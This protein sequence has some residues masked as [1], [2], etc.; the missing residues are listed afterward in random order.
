MIIDVIKNSIELFNQKDPIVNFF[1]QKAADTGIDFTN[2]RS[3]EFDEFITDEFDEFIR[4]FKY[5]NYIHRANLIVIYWHFVNSQIE[6]VAD[7]MAVFFTERMPDYPNELENFIDIVLLL[8]RYC[9]NDRN[10]FS[11]MKIG[12]INC[13][14]NTTNT[15]IEITNKILINYG[16]NPNAVHPLFRAYLTVPREIY[17]Q[18]IKKLAVSMEVAKI[19]IDCKIEFGAKCSSHILMSRLYHVVNFVPDDREILVD[20]E[21]SCE[22]IDEIDSVIRSKYFCNQKSARNSM[23][24]AESS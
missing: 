11:N 17:I 16:V 15:P 3:D 22:I 7:H 4:E 1:L 23:Y 21:I 20:F 8:T 12:G 24:V 19:I 18:N 9:N 13:S 2:Q 10:D 6:K 5:N 14:L